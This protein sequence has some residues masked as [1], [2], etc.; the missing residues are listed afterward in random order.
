MGDKNTFIRRIY[1]NIVVHTH[2][3]MSILSENR[4][5]RRTTPRRAHDEEGWWLFDWLGI[6]ACKAKFNPHYL[7]I[8]A[9]I[10]R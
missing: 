7:F 2:A 6:Y 10:P 1:E 4:M 3:N 9:N 8:I 5:E